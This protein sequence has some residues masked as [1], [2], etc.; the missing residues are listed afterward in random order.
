MWERYYYFNLSNGISKCIGDV[1]Y[2]PKLV[3][4][5]KKTKQ[6]FN[7]EFE[8]IKCWLKSCDSNKVI[9]EVI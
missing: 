7:V 5:K 8:T 1:L 6:G 3:N 2:V 4:L 9:I